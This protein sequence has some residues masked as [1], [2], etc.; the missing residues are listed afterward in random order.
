M[1][2][3]SLVL[4][5][6]LF[7]ITHFRTI[8]HLAIKSLKKDRSSEHHDAGMNEVLN[9]PQVSAAHEAYVG[10]AENLR[11]DYGSRGKAATAVDSAK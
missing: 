7:Q 10:L 6:L 2:V 3:F 1:H 4:T 8:N 11:Q 9:D 5:I